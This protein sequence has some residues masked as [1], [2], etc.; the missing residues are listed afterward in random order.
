MSYM[1]AVRSDGLNTLIKVHVIT[2]AS[3]TMFPAG[4]DNW[5]RSIIIKVRSEARDNKANSEIIDT[6]SR[7]FG[8]PSKKVSIITGGRSRDKILL[9]S[10]VSYGDICRRLEESI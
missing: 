9:L 10:N 2:G 7:F 5:R 1:D 6:V 8:L 4:Y 3:K